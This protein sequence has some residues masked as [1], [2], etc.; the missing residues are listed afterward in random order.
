VN[1]SSPSS[2][3]TS[4][5][6]VIA[7]TGTASDESAIVSVSVNGAEAVATSTNFGTWTAY[8]TLSDGENELI[9]TAEDIAGNLS[10]TSSPV[11]VSYS[12]TCNVDYD[13]VLTFDEDEG[14]VAADSSPS[15]LS[16]VESGT[17]RMIGVF[18]NAAMFSGSG[19]VTVADDPALSPTDAF[20]VDLWYARDGATTDYEVLVA[21]GSLTGAQYVIA[22]YSTFLGCGGV[23]GA[24]D[25]PT[26]TTSG[27]N[28]GELHHVACVFDGADLSLYVDGALQGST[29]VTGGLVTNS[30]D[31]SIGGIG[32]SY[33][34]TGAIDNVRVRAEALSAAEVASLYTE[35]E[36]C[37]VSDN[38]ALT[39][40][41]TASS[42]ASSNYDGKKIIDGNT[43]EDSYSDQTY[44][45]LPAS[46]TGYVTVDLGGLVGVTR[47]RWVNTHHGPR[48]SYA[49]NA[50]TIAVSDTGSFAGEETLLT[51]DNGELETTLRYHQL[52]L[53][54][55]ATARYV[56]FTVGS[57]H[58]L[59]GGINELEIYGLE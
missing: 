3:S 19:S 35:S 22:A 53:S 51:S 10:T 33:G 49:T 45:L 39:G 32:G 17:D 43:A 46:R 18:G 56:R 47:I 27:F 30:D 1:I 50:Y 6:S 12:D 44:W 16:G 57:Y 5:T 48:Y 11:T 31:L 21:K 15:G 55:P 36:P 13:L 28:D 59:G 24:G 42:S 8:V 20:T 40:T 23:D 26:V 37:A 52:D 34:L 14:G 54:A 29:A 4:A 41:V 2:G 58:S 9:V 25:T 38:L 7:V